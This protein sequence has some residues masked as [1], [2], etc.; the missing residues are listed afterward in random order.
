MTV[1]R[2]RI[3]RTRPRFN[4]WHIVFNLLYNEE[5]IDLDTILDA[6]N[7]SGNYVG[8]CDSRPRYGQFVATVEELD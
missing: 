8:L 1:Q 5:K 7:Y 6:M 3:V 4:Q 2:S